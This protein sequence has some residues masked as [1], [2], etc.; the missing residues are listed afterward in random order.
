MTPYNIHMKEAFIPMIS[1]ENVEANVD[2][3]IA[4][5]HTMVAGQEY[6]LKPNRIRQ[7][8]NLAILDGFWHGK[9]YR[10]GVPQLPK[11]DKIG[12]GQRKT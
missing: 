8:Q 10:R 6:H 5:P 2:N 4:E 12:I 9:F 11:S 1:T 3:H 7:S